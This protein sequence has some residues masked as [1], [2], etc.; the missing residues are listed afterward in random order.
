[1]LSIFCEA[2]ERQSQERAA[3]LDQACHGD[4]AL[5]ARVEALLE[6]EPQVGNFLRSEASPP[7]PGRTVDTHITEG[8]GTVI[9]PY[10]LMEQIGEGGMGLVFVAEQQQA[11]RRKVALKVIKP[12]MDSRAVIA[13]FEAERQALA[14]MDHP[15]IAKVHDGGT[16]P[17]GRPYF[18]M[19]LV[20]GVPITQFCDENRLTPR[21]RLELFVTVCEA[22]QHSHQK[23]IIHRDLKPSNV[24]VKSHDGKPVVKVI[25]FGVAKALGERLTD[26]TVYTQF[27]QWI[28]TPLYMAP[29]Q[30]GESSLDV[31]TRS[32]IYALGVLL[33]ELLTGTTPFDKG[34]LRDASYDELRRIIRE[35]EPPRP[36]TRL[37]TLGQAATAVCANCKSDPEQLRLLFRSELD[38]VVMKALEKDR[39][40]RYETALEMAADIRRHLNY[41]PVLACPP[42]MRYRLRK[43]LLKHRGPIIAGAT[44]LALLLVGIAATTTAYLHARTSEKQAR[45]AESEARATVDFLTYDM[46][47]LAPQGA[48]GGR[49]REITVREALDA[50]APTVDPTLGQNPRVEAAV[51]HVLGTTYRF[52]GDYDSARH[53]LE[54][55][56]ALRCR[57]LG[58]EDPATLISQHSL[59]AVLHD[60]GQLAEAETLCR[61]I[62]NARRKQL[63][64][65]DLG[66]PSSL[67]LLGLILTD[68]GQPEQ[69]EPLVREA[70]DLF[71]RALTENHWRTVNAQS[72]LGGCLSAQGRYAEAEPLLLGACQALLTAR[73]APRHHTWRALELTVRL[74]EAWGK[75][76]KAA[77]WRKTLQTVDAGSKPR[78]AADP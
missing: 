74:Y 72:V 61:A 69:A 50:T 48:P 37:S 19:E 27:A 57:E 78:S 58:G 33:Y 14:L 75:R 53:Q 30:A 35:E 12:G 60:Q 71:T 55:A 67:T 77:T 5:R 29:E 26:K 49:G 70:L 44:V 31:D 6:A 56:V 4:A 2:R 24:M 45:A 59:C 8:A 62:L 20:K 15:N 47:G 63:P 1:M 65:G 28:G 42:T 32:D 76:D 13:R 36:S 11:I 41:E 68:K 17:A 16:T 46:L 10:K 40:R 3:F 18:V 21:E 52:L 34:R 66:I 9:G 7:E 25:D 64:A 39:N 43:L 54:R 23:G 38:W 22:V 73:S 51:R